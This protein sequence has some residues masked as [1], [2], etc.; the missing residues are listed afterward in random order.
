MAAKSNAA[1]IFVNRGGEVLKA[2][3]RKVFP[4]L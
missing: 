1:E 4:T 3:K 2:A